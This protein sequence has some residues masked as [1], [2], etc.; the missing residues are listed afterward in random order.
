M[1]ARP[2]LRRYEGVV[3][4]ASVQGTLALEISARPRLA[5]PA[6]SVETGTGPGHCL[7]ADIV[8]IEQPLRRRLEAWAQRYAQAAVEIVGG[9]RPAAQ[10]LRW[11]RPDV[12]ADLCR[13]AQLVARA[14]GSAPGQ[15]RP[16]QAVRPHVVSVRA[17]FVTLDVCEVSIRVRHGERFRAVAARFE[18]LDGRL[19][20]TALEFA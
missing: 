8:S 6:T 7:V 10:L 5:P 15:G 3:P 12:Y 11:T 2:A 9:H 18:T 4:V 14:A 13:R 20:C 17:S 16:R 1:S 19:Q